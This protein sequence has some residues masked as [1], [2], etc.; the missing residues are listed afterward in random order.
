M[1]ANVF[2]HVDD[3]WERDNLLR[4]LSIKS[5]EVENKA[6]DGKVEDLIKGERDHKTE[7]QSNMREGVAVVRC[8]GWHLEDG[9]KL[10]NGIFNAVRQNQWTW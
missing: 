3:W 2:L 1:V 6:L 4:L 9:C 10:D 8:S 5:L 7:I